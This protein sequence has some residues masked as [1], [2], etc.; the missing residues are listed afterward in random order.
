MTSRGL[1]IIYLYADSPSE[2][3]C[4]QWRAL[5]P[6]D[7]INSEHEAGR[8]AHTA[9]LFQLQTSLNWRHPA[10]QHALGFADVMIFQRNIIIPEVW[11]AMDYWRAL[12]KTVIVDLDDGYPLLPPSNPAFEYWIRNLPQ[13][14][15]HPVEALTEGLKHADALTSPSKVIVEDW[16]SIV[17][18]FWLPNWTRLP[19]YAPLQ[20]KPI[21][22]WKSVV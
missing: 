15:P 21:G 11:E 16:K 2:W 4:S 1:H 22:G 17:P 3:N 14:D 18:G 19:W 8:T 7:A 20:Q 6:S 10:V 13:L 5:S 9:Q 12:G